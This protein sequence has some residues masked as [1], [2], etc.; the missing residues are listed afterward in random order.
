M[1]DTGKSKYRATVGK[2]GAFTCVHHRCLHLADW[3]ETEFFLKHQGLRVSLHYF[4]IHHKTLWT[5]YL[6][7]Q[8]LF[9]AFL[10][11]AKAKVKIPPDLG[12][13]AEAFS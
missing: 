5:W 4:R 9:L 8:E 7:E 12:S 6:I 3:R 11:T 10:N 1:G 2:E 13:P